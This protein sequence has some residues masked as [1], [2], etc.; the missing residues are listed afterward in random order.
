M[1]APGT[2]ENIVSAHD[3]PIN[4]HYALPKEPRAPTRAGRLT[5]E[6]KARYPQLLESNP[7][8]IEELLKGFSRQSR[9]EI[10][11]ELVRAL[12]AKISLVARQ[13]QATHDLT[14]ASARIE[15]LERAANR[16]RTRA[17]KA[18]AKL[19]SLGVGS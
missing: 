6:I 18:E 3:N 14:L 9:A 16:E 5:Q 8:R 19:K 13:Q 15:G 17:D 11:D 4:P 12:A 2:G 10:E 7:R 1:R